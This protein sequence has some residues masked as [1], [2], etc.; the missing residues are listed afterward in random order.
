MLR[1]C[2]ASRLKSRFMGISWARPKAH[3]AKILIWMVLPGRIELTTSPLPREC[4]TTE[5]RQRTFGGLADRAARAPK[6]GAK[7]NES[8]AILATEPLSAQAAG[9]SDPFA[10]HSGLAPTGLAR[11][12]R[13][14]DKL[15]DE[16]GIHIRRRWLVVDSGFAADRPRPGMTAR[17][18]HQ[19]CEAS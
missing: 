2:E 3:Q 6:Y 9:V 13:P 18:R 17:R 8:A 12:G 4:S 1:R 7:G 15:R 11:S 10:R 19:S 14:D 16:S 5:L